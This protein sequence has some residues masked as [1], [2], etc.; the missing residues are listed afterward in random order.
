MLFRSVNQAD[1][2]SGGTVDGSAGTDTLA[3]ASSD[4][5]LDL[6]STT[7]SSV[8]VILGNT[9]DNVVTVNQ[10]DLLSGGT[11]SG[12]AGTD[13]LALVSS[14]TTLDLSSTTLS[15]VEVILGNT[16]D[17]VVTVNQADLLSGGT[18]DGSSGTDT[19]ALVSSEKI[20]RAHV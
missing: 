4:T 2:L 1:L 13:T 7:L 8:E 10:A 16:N 6:S 3:L 20:G 11:V 5:T 18:V 14:E 12:S 17:N 19:L 15:S 9:N